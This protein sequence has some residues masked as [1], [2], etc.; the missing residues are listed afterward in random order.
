MKISERCLRLYFL[1]GARSTQEGEEN[2][3][4]RIKNTTN[5]AFDRRVYQYV[6]VCG[7][8]TIYTGI[9]D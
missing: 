6:S 3:Y 5:M 1:Q 2:V 7:R 4:N 9:A 8:L